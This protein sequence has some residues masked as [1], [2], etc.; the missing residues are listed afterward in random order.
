MASGTSEY[1]VAACLRKGDSPPRGTSPN[2]IHSVRWADGQKAGPS[3][4]L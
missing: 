2:N 3:F 1:E 4:N